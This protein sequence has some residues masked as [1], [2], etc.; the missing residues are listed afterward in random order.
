MDLDADAFDREAVEAAR[1]QRPVERLIDGLRLFE[2][3]CE[4]MLAGIR[5]EYPGIDPD[6]AM[7]LLRERLQL[8]RQLES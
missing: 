4:V 2:R 7:A 3:A 5:H 8:A 6:G 1:A